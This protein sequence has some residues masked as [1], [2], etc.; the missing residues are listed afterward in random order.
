MADVCS[1]VVGLLF[2]QRVP[3]FFLS[4]FPSRLEVAAQQQSL[5]AEAR[6]AGALADA[7]SSSTGK[8]VMTSPF[9]AA[10]PFRCSSPPKRH[11]QPVLLMPDGTL[12]AMMQRAAPG[13]ARC[14]GR[15]RANAIIGGEHFR[16][17]NSDG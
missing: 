2:M 13:P 14:G 10:C 12:G 11:G 3:P 1:R 9:S 4:F 7:D 6:A 16:S 15:P 17:T 8:A 5:L